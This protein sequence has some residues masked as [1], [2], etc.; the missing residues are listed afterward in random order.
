M[1]DEPDGWWGHDLT[2]KEDRSLWRET[3]SKA[4]VWGSNLDASVFMLRAVKYWVQQIPMVPV[5]G[6]MI[7]GGVLQM[8]EDWFFAGRE[9]EEVQKIFIFKGISSEKVGLTIRDR[10]LV[11]FLFVEWQ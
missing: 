10:K 4:D 5:T 1:S 6:V 7:I 9:L 8:D 11:S 3:A 2:T